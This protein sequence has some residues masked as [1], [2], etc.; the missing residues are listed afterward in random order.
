MALDDI[1]DRT[2]EAMAE[3]EQSA[4]EAAYEYGNG[5]YQQD[6]ELPEYDPPRSQFI[7]YAHCCPG[8]I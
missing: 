8:K 5:D 6:H 3:A 1:Y 2:A 7:G 4:Q